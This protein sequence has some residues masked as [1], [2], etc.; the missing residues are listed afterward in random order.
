MYYRHRLELKCE[1]DGNPPP[2]V[3]WIRGNNSEKYLEE[4]DRES[5]GITHYTSVARDVSK[6]TINCAKPEDQ[7][8]IL[9]VG[10]TADKMVISPPT[11][12]NVIGKF[13]L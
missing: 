9:C 12:I 4:I 1:V 6:Y 7:G 11:M 3:Y 10:V 13:S 2:L 8:M 5:I